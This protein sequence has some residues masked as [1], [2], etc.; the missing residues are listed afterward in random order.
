MKTDKLSPL[1]ESFYRQQLRKMGRNPN[2]VFGTS[3][4]LNRVPYS[5][6]AIGK[7]FLFKYDAKHKD[8]LPWWDRLPLIILLSATKD[9]FT[10]INLHYFPIKKRIEIFDK[11]VPKRKMS[12][13]G[14]ATQFNLKGLADVRNLTAGYKRYLKT[15]VKTKVIMIHPTEWMKT[16]YLPLEDFQ[17][18][19]KRKVWSATR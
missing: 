13:M 2:G 19:S 12:T 8:T 9:D 3:A 15:H 17:K 16:I 6:M 7:L 11:I 5:K 1:T 18:A 14:K 10:G 4:I